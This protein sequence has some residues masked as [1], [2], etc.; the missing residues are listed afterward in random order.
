VGT[1]PVG[2]HLVGGAEDCEGD[3]K[4]EAGAF[5]PEPGRRQVDRDPARRPEELGGGDPAPDPVLRLLAG[6]VRE[7]HDRE[8]RLTE[9]DVRLDLDPPRIE[10]DERVGEHPCEHGSIEARTRSRV[11]HGTATIWAVGF[12]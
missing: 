11:R 10:A 7:T 6:A 8:P 12:R 5:L 3:G 9:L 4:V 2:R 1:Q